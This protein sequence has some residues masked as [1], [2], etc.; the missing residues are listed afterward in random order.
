MTLPPGIP[1]Q[2]QALTA[3]AYWAGMVSGLDTVLPNYASEFVYTGDP[4][5]FYA[6]KNFNLGLASLTCQLMLID[7]ACYPIYPNSFVFFP[8]PP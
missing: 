6:I 2:S 7:L 3:R 1:P 4:N 8:Y 5:V